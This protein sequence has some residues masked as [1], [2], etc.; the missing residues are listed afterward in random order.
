MRLLW[1]L[2]LLALLPGCAVHVPMSQTLMFHEDGVTAPSHSTGFGVGLATTGRLTSTEH[3]QTAARQRFTVEQAVD[4]LI[5]ASN[6]EKESLGLYG[7]I[8]SEPRFAISATLGGAVAGIDMTF[9]TWQRHY[10][11][12][13][14]SLRGGAQAFLQHRTVNSSYLGL[15]LG[16]GYR[17]EHQ[18]FDVETLYEGDA[19]SLVPTYDAIPVHSVGARA[20]LVLR[21]G[22]EAPGLVLGTLYAGYAPEFRRAVVTFGISVGVF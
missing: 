17:Y 22:P 1:G 15:A 4:N 13:G 16:A 10:L 2:V 9:K 8:Y 12:I 7:S 21:P 14:S 18:L 6:L 3:L 20:L 5:D 19:P 11:T